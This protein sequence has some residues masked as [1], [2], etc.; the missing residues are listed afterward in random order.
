[1]PGESLNPERYPAPLVNQVRV[2]PTA[3]P[4]SHIPE[5]DGTIDTG[6]WITTLASVDPSAAFAVRGCGTYGNVK[7]IK[8]KDGHFRISGGPCKRYWDCPEC[9]SRYAVKNTNHLSRVVHYLTGNEGLTPDQFLFATLT[10]NHSHGTLMDRVQRF[11]KAL[12]KLTG[13]RWFDAKKGGMVLGY[14]LVWDIAGSV[15]NPYRPWINA[16]MHGLIIIK[17]GIDYRDLR[18]RMSDFMRKELGDLVRW[19]D[20][21]SVWSQTLEPAYLSR[22]TGSYLH[23]HVWKGSHEVGATILKWDKQRGAYAHHFDRDRKDLEHI[24]PLIRAQLLRIRRGGIIPMVR[25][26]LD[27]SCD[28]SYAASERESFPVPPH[29]RNASETAKRAFRRIVE[30]P[31]T[32]PWVVR[33]LLDVPERITVPE[34]EAYVLGFLIPQNPSEAPQAG[35]PYQGHS[36]GNPRTIPA[37]PRTQ[38]A[39]CLDNSSTSRT[40]VISA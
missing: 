6:A 39:S 24:Q 40:A 17:P 11:G 33:K 5:W 21:P 22:A 29:Y 23:G 13:Q 1:M 31:N 28:I 10:M 3:S 26:L 9:A 35:E 15:L 20:I 12:T 32:P 16:H 30:H 25:K 8:G 18:K 19:E 2:I 4:S 37:S 27:L 36:P 38:V 14:E 34:W 7:V